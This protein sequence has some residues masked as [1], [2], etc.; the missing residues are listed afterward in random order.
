MGN[1][2]RNLKIDYKGY[3][4]NLVLVIGMT[5]LSVMSYISNDNLE[6]ENKNMLKI[7]HISKSLSNIKESG[8]QMT[9][10]ANINFINPEDK[11][12]VNKYNE[13]YKNYKFDIAE[14]QDEVKAFKILDF[15]FINSTLD[16]PELL[17]IMNKV[18]IELNNKKLSNNSRIK[19]LKE[20]R[21]V[22]KE[23]NS[24]ITEANKLLKKSEINFKD[25]IDSSKK[26]NIGL[27]LT[28][29]IIIFLLIHYVILHIKRPLIRMREV[30]ECMNSADC[31]TSGSEHMSR[32]PADRK[33]EFND[34]AILINSMLDKADILVNEAE[35]QNK[36]VANLLKESNIIADEA[37]TGKDSLE[38]A[39]NEAKKR[40]DGNKL[41]V[42]IAGIFTDGIK[43][44]ITNVQ[45]SFVSLSA[46]SQ[47]ISDENVIVS[48]IVEKSAEETSVVE[49]SFGQISSKVISSQ[50]TVTELSDSVK[51]ITK[52]V[53][54]I[55]DIAEQTNLLALNAAIE[56]ARAGE[57]GRGFAVV[58]DE[59]RKLAEKSQEVTNQIEESL[60]NLTENSSNIGENTGEIQEAVNS[61][62]S[63]IDGFKKSMKSLFTKVEA[64]Q[65]ENENISNSSFVNLTKIDHLAF[66]TD[67][68][69][70]AMSNKS[71]EV[72][73]G[74]SCRLGKW[75]VE[76]GKEKFGL[77]PSFR[78]LEI[79]HH[80]IHN[81]AKDI[82]DII[83]NGEII[84]KKE[85]VV[86][87]LKSMEVASTEV[88]NLLD[89]MLL[90]K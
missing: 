80:A 64:I 16:S 19:F 7:E 57:H 22:K 62:S 89:S 12:A 36:K 87:D 5:T 6:I 38:V 26:W 15:S 61:A 35:E 70:Y 30:L 71:K 53:T 44:D 59:V 41:L 17:K 50:E 37:R 77:R 67:I 90:E 45:A 81:K 34:V 52:L 4:I 88:Y 46:T 69:S 21:S 9:S 72:S 10:I 14:L 75:Y 3:L 84:E 18:Q 24:H 32:L 42:D 1:F 74:Y 68:Y 43:E 40:E 54:T 76:Q 33:D 25:H 73:D 51:D 49:N 20:W 31:D 83:S 55:Q 66:K 48:Q 39:M 60:E 65:S 79:P 63:T 82:S 11:K 13:V 58:A 8:I 86:E 27:M 28:V 2:I 78:N 47:K 85:I 56:S 23:L 29:N